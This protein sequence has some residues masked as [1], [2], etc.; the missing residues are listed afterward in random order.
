MNGCVFQ[1]I[2]GRSR[3]NMLKIL[4]FLLNETSTD[5]HSQGFCG[6]E[7]SK[8]HWWNLVGKKFQIGNAYSVIENKLFLSVFVVDI[9][10]AGKKRNLAPIRWY[11]GANTFLDHVYLGCIQRECDPNEKI[12]GQY[13]KMFES[14]VSC[15]ATEKL[16]GWQTTRKN[17]S[18]VLRHVRTFSWNGISNWQTRRQS[19]FPSLARIGFP[20]ILWSV[21]IGT[22]CHKMDSSMWLTDDWNE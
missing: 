4:L 6:K 15:E 2:N 14:R 11:W 22:I 7:S 13:N 18:V 3:G 8:E 21:N 10:M 12:N 17:V 9:K 20:D 1:N 5:T 16:T 19:N